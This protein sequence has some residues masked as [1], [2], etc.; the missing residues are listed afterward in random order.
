MLLRF[1]S[2]LMQKAGVAPDVTLKVRFH[3]A[4][5]L[6]MSL[7][8]WF[9]PVM[10]F[11]LNFFWPKVHFVGPLK[12]RSHTAIAIAKVILLKWVHIIYIRLFTLRFI[13]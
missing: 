8:N 5:A 9:G 13:K 3:I 1:T 7:R 10:F 2:L 4:I 11:F 6:A 12:D